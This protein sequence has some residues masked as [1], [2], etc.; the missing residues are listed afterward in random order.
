[1]KFIKKQKQWFKEGSSTPYNKCSCGSF[2]SVPSKK[3]YQCSGV[4]ED[5]TKQK[6]IGKWSKNFDSCVFCKTTK[7]EHHSN[8]LCVVCYVFQKRHEDPTIG[9]KNR[10][11]N[12]YDYCINCKIRTRKHVGGGLCNKCFYLKKVCDECGISIN[13]HSIKCQKC[14]AK[15]RTGIKLSKE[16]KGKM[17]LIK[18]EQYK[19][20]LLKNAFKSG[21]DN[22]MYGKHPSPETSEKK[23][24][25]MKK[26]IAEGNLKTLFKNG[27]IPWLKDKTAEED[28]RILNQENHWHW[29]G[30]I[31]PIYNQI[32]N[33]LTSKQWRKL[34]FERDNYIC[35]ECNQYGHELRAHH[36]RQFSKHPNLR[37]NITN[38]ITLCKE[39]HDKIRGQEDHFI[40]YFEQK[41]N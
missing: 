26:L 27:H 37:F 23:R 29:K 32:R 33:S 19:H 2:K 1:M 11:A 9:Y 15:S 6:L 35:S 17:S 36:I 8:G 30:G 5:G 41:I 40:N 10:W 18:K 38:G 28:P 14:W 21:K 24:Q 34:V 16:T 3:C 25:S 20:G 12:H 31:T 39:C 7:R 22:P 13:I 4:N